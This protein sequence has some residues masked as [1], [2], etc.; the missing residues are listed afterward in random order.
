MNLVCKPELP[1]RKCWSSGCSPWRPEMHDCCTQWD[2][3]DTW[4]AATCTNV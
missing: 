4:P 2:Q 3:W 1:A